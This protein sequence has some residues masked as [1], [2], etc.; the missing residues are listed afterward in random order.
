MHF[1]TSCDFCPSEV[2]FERA[3][4]SVNSPFTKLIP[5]VPGSDSD[6]LATWC[7]SC[8]PKHRA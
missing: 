5:V 6:Y 8:G 4:I 3:Y 2:R 1:S 7:A